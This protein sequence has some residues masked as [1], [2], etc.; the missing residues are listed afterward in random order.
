VA[1]A[2][3][4]ALAIAVVT[5]ATGIFLVAVPVILL[6]GLAARLFAGRSFPRP[7]VRR[8]EPRGRGTLIEGEYTVV[9]TRP[10]NGSA[11]R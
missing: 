8:P 1:G 9:S 7:P 5:V 4:L 3:L 2:A 11:P 10:V 6:T